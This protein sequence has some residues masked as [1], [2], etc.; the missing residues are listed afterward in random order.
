MAVFKR[1]KGVKIKSNHPHWKDARW[2]VQLKVQGK[3]IYQSLPTATTEAQAR[4]AET[5]L[6]DDAFNRTFGRGAKQIGFTEFFENT[7]LPQATSYRDDVSRGKL[8]KAYFKDTALRDIAIPEIERFLK[9]ILGKKT[10]R[11]NPRSQAT[12]NRYFSLLSGVFTCAVRQEPR[13]VDFNPCLVLNKPKERARAR[14]MTADEQVR[15]ME[16]LIGDL[17]FLI[18]PFELA[19]NTGLRKDELVSIKMEHVNFSGVP[20]FCE[21]LEILPNWLL[22]IDSKTGEPRQV[23]MNHIVRDVLR[24]IVQGAK[25][26]ELIFTFPRN[27]VSWSTIRRGFERA[28]KTAKIAFGEKI[29]GGIVWRDLRR[30]FATRLRAQGTHEYDIKTLL[31]HKIPGVTSTYARYTPQV[32]ENAVE[33]LAETKGRIVKFERRAG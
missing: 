12:T 3:R 16:V 6:K 17:E 11:L 23:P 18:T 13:V 25:P 10:T 5:K 26:G 1:W 21:G 33:L 14:Y 31:G 29:S 24:E 2:T 15:L 30:T 9:S 28:C 8:L 20:T 19:V 32:L 7:Y 22:V 27:A 4:S